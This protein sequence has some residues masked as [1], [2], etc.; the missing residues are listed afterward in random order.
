MPM[1]T[2]SSPGAISQPTADA[3]GE[4]ESQPKIAFLPVR[5]RNTANSISEPAT[6]N[7][8]ASPSCDS[9]ARNRPAAPSPGCSARR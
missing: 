6:K 8:I 1:M 2:A 7:S 9:V 3:D 5:P 4:A